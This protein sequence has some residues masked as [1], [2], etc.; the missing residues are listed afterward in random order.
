[1][2]ENL[3]FIKGEGAFSKEDKTEQLREL[4][5]EYKCELEDLPRWGVEGRASKWAE[6]FLYFLRECDEDE[7]TAMK[8]AR[9]FRELGGE[10]EIVSVDCDE[11]RE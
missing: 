1:M 6:P 3:Q 8:I 7:F 4:L 11:I 2:K 9:L 5:R 10:A